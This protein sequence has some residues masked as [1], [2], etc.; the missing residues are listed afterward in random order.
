MADGDEITYGVTPVGACLGV[1]LGSGLG[2]ATDTETAFTFPIPGSNFEAVVEPEN[3]IAACRFQINGGSPWTVDWGDGTPIE[4]NSGD[5]PA[6]VPTGTITVKSED[7]A[8]TFRC[9]NNT[10]TSIAI[11]GGATLN[12]AVLMCLN[13]SKM[14]AFS[15]DT[16][17]NVANYSQAWKGCSGLTSFPLIDVSAAINFSSA[18][19]DCSGLTS[20][21]LLVLPATLVNLS[22]SWY[23]CTGLTSFPLL[24]TSQV[25]SF[26]SA[27]ANCTDLTSF[28]LI[29]TSTGT[30]FSGAWF[31]CGGLTTFP[32]LDMSSA[33]GCVQTWAY[34]Y[35]FSTFPNID[36]SNVTSFYECFWNAQQM[37]AFT[38]TDLSSGVDFTRMF[39]NCINLISLGNL[40]TEGPTNQ[41]FEK[42]FLACNDLETIGAIDTTGTI[43][44]T[45]G[46]FTGTSVLTS[47][48]ASEQTD[49]GDSNGADFN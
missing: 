40:I 15:I 32:L 18:W 23:G 37:T 8:L 1:S 17:E 20:F 12:G 35:G 43:G 34:C 6:V 36:L 42:M 10:I 4:Y 9:I 29:D 47:P 3:L 5:T 13:L 38:P 49:L 46:M 26:S 24:D 22:S 2:P 11:T 16:M 44:T 41:I 25:N 27:W 19:Y 30:S 33:T 45:L 28:P 14:T 39:E 7:N 31:N 48:N 21:P